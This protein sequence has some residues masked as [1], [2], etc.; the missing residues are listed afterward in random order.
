MKPTSEPNSRRVFDQFAGSYE[1]AMRKSLSV[2]HQDASMFA[3]LKAQVLLEMAAQLIGDLSNRTALDVGCGIGLA[4]PYLV[5][6]FQRVTGVDVSPE[7]VAEAAR[8]NPTATFQ[9]YDGGRLPFDDRSFDLSFAM[10][11]F[12]HVPL[13]LRAR[14]AAEMTRVVRP[15]GLV[16]VFDHNPL[17]PLTR[18]SVGHC[19]FD[20][21]VSLLRRS[22]VAGLL[23]SAGLEVAARRYITFFPWR[24]LTWRRI[25]RWL[26]W[27]P[28]GGQH[29]TVGRRVKP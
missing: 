12:H 21:D 9:P 10:G 18:Y 24:G 22:S 3:E 6:R 11:V 14:L 2:V 15:G 26:G 17:N 29:V 1:S 4:E 20:I 13:L 28:L 19:D 7:S 16:M 25:E 8:R 23:R 5:G 27:L